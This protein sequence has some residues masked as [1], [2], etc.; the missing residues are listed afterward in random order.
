MRYGINNWVYPG[1]SLRTSF[2]RLARFG[3][4]GIEL[5]GE[6]DEFPK[7]TVQA[8][9]EE[10]G[11]EVIS[12]LGWCIYPIPGRDLASTD[13]AERAAAQNYMHEVIEYAAEVGAGIVL[14]L[15]FPA[16]RLAPLSK[17]GDEAAWRAAK[18]HEWDLAVDSVRGLAEYATKFDITLTIEPINRFETYQIN[19]L[20]DG[21]RFIEAV[22]APNVRLNLDT[23]HMNIDEPDPVGAI[24]KA[25]SL[26]AHMHVADSNHMPPGNGHVDFKAVMQALHDIDFAGAIVLEAVPPGSD[27]GLAVSMPSN[28]PLRDQY[29]EQTIRYLKQLEAAVTA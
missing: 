6:L 18:Q 26:L 22:G 23:F 27:A 20:A 29:A 2:E 9:C 11:L 3:Y 12:I 17:P 4:D 13:A 25:G 24:R 1:E 28:L 7:E 14:T 16:G 10:F 8:L 15:P 5:K 19:T 21:L